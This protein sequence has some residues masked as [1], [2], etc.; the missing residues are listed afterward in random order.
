MKRVKFGSDMQDILLSLLGWKSLLRQRK[1]KKILDD[2]DFDI[3]KFSHS[4]YAVDM[5]YL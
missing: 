4:I 5:V 3:Q 2:R 1:E